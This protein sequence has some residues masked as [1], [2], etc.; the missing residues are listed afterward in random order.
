MSL[1]LDT[2]AWLWW[3]ADDPRLSASARQAIGDAENPVL[4]SVDMAM[5]AIGVALLW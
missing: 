1:L 2:H 5:A 4:V 3:L